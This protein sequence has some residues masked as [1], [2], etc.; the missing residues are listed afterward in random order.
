MNT[1]L[2]LHFFLLIINNKFLCS[3]F[4]FHFCLVFFMQN[5]V[6]PLPSNLLTSSSPSTYWLVKRTILHY[7]HHRFACYEVTWYKKW[8]QVKNTR[9]IVVHSQCDV[10]ELH[11]IATVSFHFEE[12]RGLEFGFDD[13]TLSFHPTPKRRLCVHTSDTPLLYKCHW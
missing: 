7:H 8:K 4:Y 6:P 9:Y 10:Q 1:S 12:K 2:A 5:S 13:L 11:P 3:F